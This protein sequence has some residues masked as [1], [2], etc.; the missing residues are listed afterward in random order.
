MVAIGIC[1]GVVQSKRRCVLSIKTLNDV[2]RFLR[3]IPFVGVTFL[4][5]FAKS[6]LDLFDGTFGG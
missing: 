4:L 5:L 3:G 6:D 2:L 1:G